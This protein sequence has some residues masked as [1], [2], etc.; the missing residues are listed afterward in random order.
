MFCL[1]VDRLDFTK[2]IEMLIEFFDSQ[3]IE[4]QAPTLDKQGIEET[5]KII[6]DKF[7]LSKVVSN[8][9]PVFIFPLNYSQRNVNMH[10]WPYINSITCTAINPALAEENELPDDQYILTHELGHLLV[11]KLSD[12]NTVPESF[13]PI[14]EKGFHNKRENVEAEYWPELFA[15][16]F[17]MAAAYNTELA[18]TNPFMQK[19]F[20]SLSLFE[21]YFYN[22]ID[23]AKS[24]KISL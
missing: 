7:D 20:P 1:I 16:T 14:F 5:L 10:N 11:A 3:L 8:P 12:Y 23:E 2:N 4:P 22:I 24:D 13:Y 21:Q 9:V 19:L 18:N 15:D 17:S 6:E